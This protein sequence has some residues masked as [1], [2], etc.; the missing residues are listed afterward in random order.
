MRIISLLSVVTIRNRIWW[1]N[2][3]VESIKPFDLIYR[4]L[5]NTWFTFHRNCFFFFF[6][7]AHLFSQ[8]IKIWIL[9]WCRQLPSVYCAFN[10]ANLPKSYLC[11]Y[12]ITIIFLWWSE[13]LVY[14]ILNEKCE[15]FN[16]CMRKS[17][18]L[19]SLKTFIIVKIKPTPWWGFNQFWVIF[20][21]KPCYKGGTTTVH[22]INILVLWV[23]WSF[24]KST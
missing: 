8:H 4:H 6:G 10:L 21:I 20:L 5:W 14:L 3:K 22:S 12:P 19:Y 17:I 2:S 9:I 16:A 24:F 15:H 1:S 18:G 11:F 7:F 23:S 13:F